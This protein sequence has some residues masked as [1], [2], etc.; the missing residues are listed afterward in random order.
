MHCVLY[1][2]PLVGPVRKRLSARG[3]FA[4]SCKSKLWAWVQGTTTR[5]LCSAY[6]QARALWVVDAKEPLISGPCLAGAQ[7]YGVQGTG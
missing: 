2:L 7:Q 3:P 5:H 6:A 4:A 1:C